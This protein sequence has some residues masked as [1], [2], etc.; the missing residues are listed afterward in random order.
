MAKITLTD[1]SSG[2]Q[3]L[4]TYNANNTLL[5]AAIENTLSRDGTSPNTM[6]A[7][8]DMNSNK[9]VNVL[10]ATDNQDA[11]TL[12]QLNAA[13]IV[14]ATI[15]ASAVTLVDAGSNYATDTAEAAFAEVQTKLDAKGTLTNVV[16]DTTPQLGGDLDVNSN[17]INMADQVLSRPQL[18]DF[19]ITSTSPSSSTNVIVLDLALGNT[20]QTTLTEN[21]TTVTLSNPPISGI[22][23]EIA[24][25]VTQD[26]SGRTITWPASV[27]WA[28]GTAPIISA[29]SGAVD[30]ISLKTW[31]AGTTWYGDFSQAY[32]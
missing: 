17:G 31:D 26:S 5:E 15:A 1:I 28:G 29:G 22:F 10:D 25:K 7:D 6:A 32:A 11:V 13:S 4:S 30:I 23:G 12:A 20:F 21:I 14:A 9:V 3:S 24:W 19:G 16:E 18:K 2:Y 8:I 27:L